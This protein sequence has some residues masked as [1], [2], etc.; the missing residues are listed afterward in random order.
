MVRP[1]A[2]YTALHDLAVNGVPGYRTGD[3]VTAGVVETMGW[4]VGVDV[5][6]ANPDVIPRPAD[7]ADRAA[8]EAFAIGQ[9]MPVADAQAASLAEL[10]DAYPPEPERAD[11]MPLPVAMLAPEPDVAAEAP[12]DNGTRR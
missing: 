4:V 6:P 2:E 1:R 8:W 5:E 3:D 10:R 7:D 11:F 12:E 9:G